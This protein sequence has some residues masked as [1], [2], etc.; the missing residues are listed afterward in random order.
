MC[1]KEE[2]LKFLK[3]EQCC[4]NW[5]KRTW[6]Y[7]WMRIYVFQLYKNC[8]NLLQ[9]PLQISSSFTSSEAV[10]RYFSLLYRAIYVSCHNFNV[11]M[12]RKIVIVL[13]TNSENCFGACN[14]QRAECDVWLPI[15]YFILTQQA[16]TR[17]LFI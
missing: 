10:N 15:Y 1:F 6:I 12:L 16:H 11:L 8:Y 3:K 4:Q 17:N 9:R 14:F 7:W 2:W 5:K 13:I